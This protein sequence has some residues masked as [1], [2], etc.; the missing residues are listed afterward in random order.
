MSGPTTISTGTKPTSSA[1][2]NDLDLL[3]SL[4][5][6]AL[7][8]I[9]QLVSSTD[10]SSTPSQL[11]ANDESA[12][13]IDLIETF[14]PTKSTSADDG[15]LE[16][17]GQ[18]EPAQALARAYMRDMTEVRGRNDGSLDRLGERVDDVRD[19]A[20]RV[21]EALADVKV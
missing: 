8:F 19:K 6:S 12:K 9:R 7:R 18:I 10:T 15:V 5:P 11:T 13:A 3:R 2:G 20:G 21:G 1:I 4:P 17:Q 14:R 16:G